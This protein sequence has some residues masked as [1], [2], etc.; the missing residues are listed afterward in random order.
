MTF[1][2]TCAK[3]DGFVIEGAC[4]N[5]GAPARAR[6][7]A[8]RLLRAGGVV[9]GGAL[10]FTLMACYGMPPCE[11]PGACSD[12]PAADAGFKGD[13][14]P[15]RDGSTRADASD[16]GSASDGGED[17]DA[18]DGGD[19]GDAGSAADANDSGRD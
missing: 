11:A 3:C 1:F 4:P 19:A 5:C 14:G 6:N 8:R 9:G 2:S 16:S 12:E 13:A 17:G 15:S 7:V 10:A 18:G